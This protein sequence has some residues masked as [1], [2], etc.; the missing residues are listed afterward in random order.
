MIWSPLTKSGLDELS[1]PNRNKNIFRSTQ[2]D[3]V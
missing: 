2:Y 3:S 1:Y